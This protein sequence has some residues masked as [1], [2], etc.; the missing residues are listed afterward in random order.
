[1]RLRT[2]AQFNG[3]VTG[4]TNFSALIRGAARGFQEATNPQPPQPAA[5]FRRRSA[6]AETGTIGQFLNVADVRREPAAVD[7]A[8]E[9]FCVGEIGDHIATAK[10][11][12]I[13]TVTTRRE[14]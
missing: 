10:I 8:A 12:R 9:C 13:E 14:V 2:D 11:G 4:K 3:G 6:R 5:L 1:V 7:D